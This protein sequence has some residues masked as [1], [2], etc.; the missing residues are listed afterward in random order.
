MHA[1]THA[2]ARTCAPMPLL[3]SVRTCVLRAENGV[4]KAMAHNKPHGV[5]ANSVCVRALSCS[6]LPFAPRPC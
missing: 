4:H 5:L 1:R 3:A 2:R 6:A